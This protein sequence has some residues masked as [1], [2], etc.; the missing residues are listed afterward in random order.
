MNKLTRKAKVGPPRAVLAEAARC[1]VCNACAPGKKNWPDCCERCSLHAAVQSLAAYE[2][3]GLTPE[4]IVKLN[5]FAGSEVERMLGKLQSV[6]A[7]RDKLRKA[8]ALACRVLADFTDCPGA[9]AGADF[10]ECFG[11]LDE[12]GNVDRW[13]CWQRYFLERVQL[14]PVCRVCGCTQNN[15]CPGG[16]SWIEPDLCSACAD[17]RK[18]KN[19]N[20]DD[21]IRALRATSPLLTHKAEFDAAA[22]LIESLQARVTELEAQLSASR[23]REQAAVEDI[24]D[25][26]ADTLDCQFCASFTAGSTCDNGPCKPRWRGPR[27]G[28]DGGSER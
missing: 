9:D 27:G 4:E 19:M 17:G 28:K 25:L 20:A 22:D 11:E 18:E 2:D 7:E 15:A 3:T 23:H 13:E 5:T 10:P 14:E 21:I 16:C 12:C 6:Q 8:F 1:E 24:H 26:L